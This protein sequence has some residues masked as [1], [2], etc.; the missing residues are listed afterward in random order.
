[1]SYRKTARHGQSLGSA[2]VK[3]RQ[4]ASLV[5]VVCASAFLVAFALAMV[6]TAGLLLSQANRR[7]DQE[8]SRQLA[9]SYA[10]VL[11]AELQKGGNPNDASKKATFYRFAC[12]FLENEGYADYNPDHPDTTV[13]HYRVKTNTAGP[14]YGTVTVALYKES[15]WEGGRI[16]GEISDGSSDPSWDPLVAVAGSVQHATLTVE[17]TVRVDDMSYSYSTVYD[18]K[19]HY[20]DDAVT[21]TAAGGDILKW[22]GSANR[23]EYLNGTHYPAGAGESIYYEVKPGLVMMEDC[24]FD[25]TFREKGDPPGSTLPEGGGEVTGP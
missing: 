25:K 8:R 22:N 17:V 3:P 24:V 15:D 13:Y 14:E 5:I 1:M 23:W 10:R 21:F 12:N 7:L 16:T 18:Q 4:G 20:I 11:E 19:A 2:K 9:R 6:Y